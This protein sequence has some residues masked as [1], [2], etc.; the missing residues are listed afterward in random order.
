MIAQVV[1][2]AKVRVIG[3]ASGMPS[4]Q[5]KIGTIIR[6]RYY[7]TM[8]VFVQIDGQEVVLWNTSLEY[9]NSEEAED[10]ARRK[11]HAD[12]YL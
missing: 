8:A 2:G 5:G 4:L 6:T 7:H 3:N 1:V 10:Q 9:V 11:A 12:K